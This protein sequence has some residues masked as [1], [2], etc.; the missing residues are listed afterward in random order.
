MS[1]EPR[2]AIVG[3]FLSH[4]DTITGR[5]FSGG[6]GKFLHAL[7]RQCG[8]DSREALMTNVF[9]T[10][11]Q[12]SGKVADLCGDKTTAVANFPML[13]KGLYIHQEHRHHLDRL[14]LQLDTFKPNCIIALGPLAAWALTKTYGVKKIRGAPLQG[15]NKFKVLVTYHPMS[16][17]R[18][19]SLYPVFAS[20]LQKAAKEALFPQVVRPARFIHV[21]PSYTDLLDFER[22]F[23]T[24]SDSLSID[25]E[26]AERQI[27]C[28]GF[29]P[30]P[31]RAI[32]IPFTDD[33]RATHNYWPDLETEMLVWEWVRRICA[34]P[35]ARIV[36]QNF[37]YDMKFLLQSY[38]I[39]VTHASDDI[40]LLHHSMQPE[41]EK[42]LGFMASIYTT[43][44]AWK[45]MR[46]K[47]TV[48]K[49]D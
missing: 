25:I 39:P 1:L 23:I 26:T 20:D 9:Q 2:I 35:K 33:T 19:Y 24:P 27:T 8:I 15:Y 46:P 36:G 17:I 18:Q 6:A 30:S 43:E 13:E 16:V 48:K 41:M 47:H 38:G 10:F 11:P 14:F 28:I 12:L 49:E 44:L 3:D 45:F 21:E 5:P 37:N 22:E 29:A 32:V 7:L 40:M 31:E 34:L 4:E 42:S